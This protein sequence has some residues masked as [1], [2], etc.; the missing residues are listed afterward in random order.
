MIRIFYLTVLISISFFLSFNSAVAVNPLE[1]LVM[2]GDVIEGH[3]KYESECSN[4]HKLFS[5]RGQDKLCLDCHKKVNRDVKKKQGFH[6]RNKSIR[7]ALCKSCHTEHKGRKADIIK[8]EKQTFDHNVTD[9][10][11]RGKHKVIE[12]T[13]CHKKNKKYREVKSQCKSCHAKESPHKKARAKKG[14]FEQ[15]QKCHRATS[16]NKIKFNHNKTKYKLTGAHK[17]ALCQSC[18]INQKYTKTPKKCISCHKLDDVHNGKNG[19]QCQKCHTTKQWGKISFNH[20]RDTSFRLK[21][22]HKKTPCKSCHKKI[23]YKKKKSKKKKVARKCFSCH[24]YDDKHKGVFGKKCNSCHHEKD[25]GWDETKFN[26][27]K[28]T[29][30]ALTGKHKK[31]ECIFCHKVK[32]KK[33]T[34]KTSCISCHKDDDIHKGNLGSKCNSC[35]TTSN[36]KKRVK[37]EHDITPFPL[38]GMHSAVSCEECHTGSGYKNIRKSCV[39]CHKNDDF[40]K[41]KLGNNCDRCHTANDWGVWFFNHNKSSKFKLRNGHKGVHCH[42]C[43][44]EAIKKVQRTPRD[45]Q[46]CHTNDDPHNGQFG[47]R[48]NDCHNTKDFSHIEM[49]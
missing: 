6:G 44:S 7:S 3:K 9:F 32:Q 40:H 14:L 8:F 35:H 23:S 21:G 20:A 19:K 41:G 16:W 31:T 29:K 45:C 37:F 49:K 4:C 48:C 25:W 11:L 28:E 47:S 5:K 2:P 36:W 26:H 39:S 27:G 24:N 18:H 38:M 22:K 13:S 46:N 1:S 42:S 17:T 10:R 34:R 43:H 30:F 33:N 15:C 12:C